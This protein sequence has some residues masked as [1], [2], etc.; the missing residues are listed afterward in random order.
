MNGH[1][2]SGKNFDPASSMQFD[3]S[4]SFLYF[5]SLAVSK[6]I[7][8]IWIRLHHPMN[9]VIWF[10]LIRYSGSTRHSLESTRLPSHPQ[11][12]TGSGLRNIIASSAAC[13]M[14]CVGRKCIM[15]TE[16]HEG[17]CQTFN[18]TCFQIW[19]QPTLNLVGYSLG[20]QAFQIWSDKATKGSRNLP[21]VFLDV[22]CIIFRKWKMSRNISES[23]FIIEWNFV[24]LKFKRWPLYKWWFEPF[25]ICSDS[26]HLQSQ[27]LFISLCQ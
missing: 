7:H 12:S 2:L 5:S 4:C 22:G 16:K 19:H 25:Y 20:F 11:L 6:V 26:T 15:T 23:V 18:A 8:G 21:R 10:L 24:H 17:H 13:V 1:E 9:G 27:T 3:S 14:W